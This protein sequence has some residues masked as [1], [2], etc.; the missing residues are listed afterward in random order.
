MLTWT[1]FKVFADDKIFFLKFLYLI[2]SK[3]LCEKEKMLIV[4]IF[5]FFSFFPT[6]ILK[7]VAEDKYILLKWWFLSLIG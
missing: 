7:T 2:E 6:M 1:K 3:T 4:N 5:F